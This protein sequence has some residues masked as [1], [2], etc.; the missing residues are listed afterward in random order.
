MVLNTVEI[1]FGCFVTTFI[2]VIASM[3]IQMIVNHN[4]EWAR[5]EKR[6]KELE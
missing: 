1:F 2:I 5:I 4:R 6:M 3:A